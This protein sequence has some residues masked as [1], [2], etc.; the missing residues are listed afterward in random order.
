[1]MEV[2]DGVRST[3]GIVYSLQDEEDVVRREITRL[4]LLGILSI[5]GISQ[6]S[7]KGAMLYEKDFEWKLSDHAR[8]HNDNNPSCIFCR[9]RID[10]TVANHKP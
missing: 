8:Y 10:L 3:L 6:L 1:M 9:R 2:L 7:K 5:V 4:H